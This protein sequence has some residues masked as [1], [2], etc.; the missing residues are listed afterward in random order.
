MSICSNKKH[1][2][3]NILYTYSISLISE[4]FRRACYSKYSWR[5]SIMFSDSA[6]IELLQ[7]FDSNTF[8]AIVNRLLIVTDFAD[9]K[10]SDCW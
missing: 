9:S 7:N 2:L 4:E 10:D 5:S 3:N 1:F 6:C 8:S